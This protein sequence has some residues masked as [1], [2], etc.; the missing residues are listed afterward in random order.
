[1]K[2]FDKEIRIAY[3]GGYVEVY[4]QETN[5]LLYEDEWV[6]EDLN[7]WANMAAEK[8]MT[9]CDVIAWVIEQ[10]IEAAEEMDDD[11]D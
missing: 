1:M 6:D 3:D 5:E 2:V 7:M 8:N 11:E 9:F 10:N 4:D